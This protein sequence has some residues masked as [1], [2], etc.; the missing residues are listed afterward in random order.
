MA[1]FLSFA[2]SLTRVLPAHFETLLHRWSPQKRVAN[3]YDDFNPEMIAALDQA[4][5]GGRRLE[6]G[7]RILT[8]G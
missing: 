4:S 5:A 2:E 6:S 8:M 3:S 1:Q 7:L